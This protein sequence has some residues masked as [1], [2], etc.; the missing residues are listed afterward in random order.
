MMSQSPQFASRIAA[1]TAPPI[2]A[3]QA[4]A[5]AYD[6]A[7]GRLFDLSQAVPDFPPHPDLLGWLAEAA[8]SPEWAGYGDI[9]GEPV[10][11]RAYAEHVSGL[12]GTRVDAGSIH[13]TAGCNQAFVA[14]VMAVAEPGKSVLLTNPCYFNHETTLSMLGIG[15]RHVDCDAA[16]GF[17]PQPAA[18][19]AAIDDS[20]RAL[21]IVSPNNPTG[22]VYPPALLAEID[23]ICRRRGI[24]LIVDETYRDFL[25]PD[26]GPPHDLLTRPGWEDGLILLYSFSKSFCIP[27]HRLGAITAGRRTV[28]HIAKVMDNLQICAPRPQQAAVARAL[29]ALGAWRDGNRREIDR[30]A[31]ALRD[32]IAG[33][34]GWEIASMGAYF[35]FVS[36]PL[37]GES[38]LRVAERLARDTGVVTIPGTFFGPGMERYLRFAF[39]N[40]DVDTISRLGTRLSRL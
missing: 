39:A 21:A 22:A 1:L 8:G 6:R 13:I 19:D 25:A 10:L 12:F 4:W 35:A 27:G 11:R 15:I 2:P 3:V 34:D 17:L 14:S 31:Q 18:I 7:F 36:H 38:S 28:A 9:E 16:A 30:R 29:P 26:A 24:W 40:V 20:V 5:K 37:E 32:V 23:A 33:T